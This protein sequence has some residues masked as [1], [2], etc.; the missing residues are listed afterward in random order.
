MK[1]R[2]L[3]LF[4]IFLATVLLLAGCKKEN[5]D[6]QIISAPML[7]FNSLEEATDYLLK[8]DQTTNTKGF[9]SYA[10]FMEKEYLDLNPEYYF[11]SK[12]EMIQYVNDHHDKYQ[13]ILGDDGEYTFEIK[14]FNHDYKYV[15]NKYGLFQVKDTIYKLIEG[16]LVYTSKS[17][18][19]ELINYVDNGN[20]E[21]NDVFSFI[22]F[23][24]FE[25][26]DKE[27]CST[28]MNSQ[29]LTK[30]NGDNK[31]YLEVK[32]Y[33]TNSNIVYEH[34]A[35]PY[36]HNFLGWF[37]C[38]RTITCSYDNEV[39]FKDT[40]GNWPQWEWNSYSGWTPPYTWKFYRQEY[41]TTNQFESVD[42]KSHPI[43][44]WM[45]EYQHPNAGGFV[46]NVLDANASTLD[47]GN[48]HILC[49]SNIY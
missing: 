13:L 39:V 11:K 37:G 1:T 4:A 48:I 23:D 2:H 35:K 12:E 3:T 30:Y 26:S 49:H 33:A 34:Y 31:L 32:V 14:M 19:Q 40:N 24:K 42:H 29:N 16:G 10:E 8:K 22:V 46:F 17:H 28:C 7:K 47:V 38:L 45:W 36:H 9:V 21:K 5:T 44:S 27:I 20:R 6:Q 18:I 25:A 41:V 43:E 15:A